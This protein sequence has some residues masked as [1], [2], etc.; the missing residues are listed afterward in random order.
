MVVKIIIME[1]FIAINIIKKM[2]VV[3]LQLQTRWKNYEW[4]KDREV[5]T[6][7]GTYLWSFE[8][9]RNG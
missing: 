2:S 9:F 7:S 1:H 8:I 6:T 5:F 4:G 3:L